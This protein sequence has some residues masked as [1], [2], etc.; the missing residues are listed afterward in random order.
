MRVARSCAAK[1]RLRGLRT[2]PHNPNWYKIDPLSPFHPDATRKLN[3]KLNFLVAYPSRD[4]NPHIRDFFRSWHTDPDTLGISVSCQ[5]INLSKRPCAHRGRIRSRRLL[6]RTII[7]NVF[8]GSGS[9]DAF[10]N[11]A[12]NEIHAGASDDLITGVQAMTHFWG[13]PITTRYL[14]KRGN[15]I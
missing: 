12:D 5:T 3:L 2:A 7:E 13:N 11:D 10:G 9:D 1:T 8:S 14:V 6:F 15:P 4:P